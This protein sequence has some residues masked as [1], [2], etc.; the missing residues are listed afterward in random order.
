MAKHTL[1]S[2]SLFLI[3]AVTI[4]QAHGLSCT[5]CNGD[6]TSTCF[7]NPGQAPP[8]ALECSQCAILARFSK[9]DGSIEKIT[10]DCHSRIF[11]TPIPNEYENSCKTD[12]QDYVQCT[13][14]CDNGDFCADSLTYFPPGWDEEKIKEGPK[15]A[16]YNGKV[17]CAVCHGI[18]DSDC[19]KSPEKVVSTLQ[20]DKCAIFTSIFKNGGAL[21]DVQRDC[22]NR[23]FP[24][25]IPVKYENTCKDDNSHFI[26]CTH[27]CTGDLCSTNLS[28]IP[29]GWNED[30]TKSTGSTISNAGS[31]LYLV[32]LLIG[33]FFYK[34]L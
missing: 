9:T 33:R 10:R 20:C 29:P 13:H 21:K 22:Y 23:I 2:F 18:A 4:P 27:T 30:G 7:T 8:V 26:E 19:H 14:T 6:T 15:P 12:V 31:S 1:C 11:P 24:N 25:P 3:V 28:L 16:E 34:L 17:T 32:S 5:I